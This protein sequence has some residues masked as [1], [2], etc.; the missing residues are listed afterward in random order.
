MSIDASF[1]VRCLPM[2]SVS[3][4]DFPYKSTYTNFIHFHKPTVESGNSEPLNIKL[5]SNLDLLVEIVAVKMCEN[6]KL[7]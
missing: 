6:S 7:L 1:R 4:Q 5:L 3:Y 2:I